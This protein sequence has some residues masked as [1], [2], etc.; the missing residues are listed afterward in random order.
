MKSILF[1]MF[2]AIT[3]L[4]QSAITTEA[5]D[6]RMSFNETMELQGIQFHV[7]SKNQNAG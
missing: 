5:G 2:M 7:T 6:Q 1:L 4:P 3:M